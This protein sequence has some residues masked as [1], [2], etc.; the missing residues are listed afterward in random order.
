ASSVNKMSYNGLYQH[1]AHQGES[2]GM[3]FEGQGITAYDN[4]KKTF[5][6]TWIDDMGRGIMVMEG[7]YDPNTRTMALAGETVDPITKTPVKVKEV[8]T[9]DSDNSYKFE[10]YT[11]MDGKKVKTMEIVYTRKK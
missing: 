1:S 2:M 5:I 8:I 10:M 7:Q 3:P 11:I 6:S 4:G 9:Y